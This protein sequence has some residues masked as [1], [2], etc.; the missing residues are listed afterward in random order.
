MRSVFFGI[1]FFYID[2][3]LDFHHKET[4]S[5][6]KQLSIKFM[7][8]DAFKSRINFLVGDKNVSY[9]QCDALSLAKVRR[10]SLKNQNEQILLILN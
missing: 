7:S 10:N 4:G 9:L 3:R 6:Q 5:H 1:D 8:L 2:G